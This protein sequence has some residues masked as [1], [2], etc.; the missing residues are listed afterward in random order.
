[1]A[2]VEVEV[3]AAPAAR[4]RPPAAGRWTGLGPGEWTPFGRGVD[5]LRAGEWT[6][7]GRG[8]GRPSGGG[9]DALRAGEWTPF[10]RSA[11]RCTL[12]SSRSSSDDIYGLACSGEAFYQGARGRR[13]V[14][15]G[16]AGAREDAG[17]LDCRC[18][19]PCEGGL[20]LASRRDRS[21]EKFTMAFQVEELSIQLIERTRSVHAAHQTTR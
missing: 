19:S 2:E 15:A 17:S 14:R 4:A 7:F 6:P 8:S 18:D 3:D 11:S 13:G 9:V 12:A 10:G 20:W 16:C 1:M 21:E 5:A